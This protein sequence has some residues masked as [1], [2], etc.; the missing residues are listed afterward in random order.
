MRTPW[1]VLGALILM[2]CTGAGSDFL[3]GGPDD[4]IA[5][6]VSTSAPQASSTTTTIATIAAPT[7]APPTTV[8]PTT[9]IPE[10][11]TTLSLEDQVRAGVAANK[12]ARHACLASPATC[13]VGTIA[14]ADSPDFIFLSQ[15]ISDRIAT[16]YFGVARPETMFV[17]RSVTMGSDA[18]SARIELCSFDANWLVDGRDPSTAADDIVV[19]DSQVTL[20]TDLTVAL[21]DAGWRSFDERLIENIVGDNRCVD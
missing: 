11:T 13:D 20:M 10:P 21:T 5:T 9:T 3:D 12:V 16:G 7:T 1:I 8:A 2:G 18:T 19:D 6:T 17:I 4:P 15:A 14:V